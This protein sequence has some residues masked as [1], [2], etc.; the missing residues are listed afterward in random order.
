[1]SSLLRQLQVGSEASTVPELLADEKQGPHKRCRYSHDVG[2]E[3]SSKPG[4]TT[5]GKSAAPQKHSSKSA[6][7]VE[8]KPCCGFDHWHVHW[9]HAHQTGYI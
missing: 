5:R 8:A 3:G 9:L 1:M 4:L 2:K 6:R 7:P